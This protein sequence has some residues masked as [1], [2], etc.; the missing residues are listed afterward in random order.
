MLSV[1]IFAVLFAIPLLPG[2]REVRNPRDGET[3]DIPNG[4]SRE[5][6]YFGRSYRDRIAPLISADSMLGETNYFADERALTVA[7]HVVPD[8]A[9]ESRSLLARETLRIGIGAHVRD[10]Y[11]TRDLHCASGAT[12]RVLCSDGDMDIDAN[13]TIERW[14]D[15]AGDLRV[16]EGCDLGVSAASTKGVRLGAS[17]RFG[18]VYGSPIRVQPEVTSGPVAAVRGALLLENDGAP[19]GDT[20]EHGDLAVAAGATVMG[21]LKAHGS[22]LIGAGAHVT[23]NVIARKDV[24]LADGAVVEGHVFAEERLRTAR[25]A[26]IGTSAAQKTAF[27]GREIRLGGETTVHGWIVCDGLGVTRA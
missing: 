10:G 18:R 16:G 4:Y 3:L 21:S 24:S 19:I 13:C 5:P 1:I 9:I 14:V 11:A 27:A 6:R 20:I 15:A 22:I 8:G 2:L 26:V 12:A 17:V 23:G 7:S 25:G